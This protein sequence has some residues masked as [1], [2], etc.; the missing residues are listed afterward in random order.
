MNISQA[1]WARAHDWYYGEQNSEKGIVILV[2]D[3]YEMEVVK[4][5][6]FKE[7]RNWAGY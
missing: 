5:T 4:F 6:N 2:R 3:I 1:N 7:L